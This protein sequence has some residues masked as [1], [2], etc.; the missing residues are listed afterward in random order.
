[1]PGLVASSQHIVKHI[2]EATLLLDV[3]IYGKNKTNSYILCDSFQQTSYSI[4]F[5]K[6]KIISFYNNVASRLGLK[7]IASNHLF[8]TVS[9]PHGTTSVPH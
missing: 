6:V 2:D 9:S 4:I 5:L 7:P 1:M 3:H 8:G